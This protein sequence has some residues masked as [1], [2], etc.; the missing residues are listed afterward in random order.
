M[1]TYCVEISLRVPPTESGDNLWTAY[2]AVFF[3][4][5]GNRKRADETY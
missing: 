1:N 3:I 2:R 4:Y 5:I